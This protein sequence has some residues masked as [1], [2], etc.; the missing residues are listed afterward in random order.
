MARSSTEDILGIPSVLR[1]GRPRADRSAGATPVQAVPKRGPKSDRPHPPFGPWNNPE[2]KLG[3]GSGPNGSRDQ[4]SE[5]RLGRVPGPS[6][7]LSMK[8]G[9]LRQE[10]A[11]PWGTCRHL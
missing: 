11:P 10:D 8:A 3:G 2:G 6:L 4:N 5:A 1:Q 7:G 9:L